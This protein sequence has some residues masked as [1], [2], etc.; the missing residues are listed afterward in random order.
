MNH[1]ALKPDKPNKTPHF[2]RV[3]SFVG[4]IELKTYTY[5][6]KIVELPSE[7]VSIV[8]DWLD[9]KELLAL[10]ATCHWLKDP[11][12]MAMSLATSASVVIGEDV[13]GFSLNG[14]GKEIR[15]SLLDGIMEK[16]LEIIVTLKCWFSK[17]REISC[18][19]VGEI[20][21]PI[22]HSISR[23]LYILT[24][25]NLEQGFTLQLFVDIYTDDP[26]FKHLLQ[27]IN[28]S[29]LQFTVRTSINVNHSD[30]EEIVLG[31]KF[32][33]IHLAFLKGRRSFNVIRFR[34]AVQR[35]LGLCV[36][37]GNEHILNEVCKTLQ[38]E[39][40]LSLIRL[41]LTGIPLDEVIDS[42][43]KLHKMNIP[44]FVLKNS[45]IQTKPVTPKVTCNSVYVSVSNIFELGF[46]QLTRVKVL[47]FNSI[48]YKATTVIRDV[49]PRLKRILPKLQSLIQATLCLR[50][51]REP[52]DY[53]P[54]RE[55]LNAFSKLP[56][57]QYLKLDFA[58]KGHGISR[59]DIN[60]SMP[61]TKL[62]Y[63]HHE[64]PSTTIC[65][66]P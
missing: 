2:F 10:R 52:R 37:I 15:V 3:C 8:C 14:F 57:L 21:D 61:E 51:A 11:A 64:P 53:N 24:K 58:C 6:M 49:I 13:A 34:N 27:Q 33:K 23:V 40:N 62:P 16:D 17:I 50:P 19:R 47:E 55:L 26:G 66:R 36:G 48:D 54:H 5:T 1:W 4:P 18:F 28:D 25:L 12:T 59:S 63:R 38:T 9:Y 42:L 32:T 35:S 7:V 43:E 30:G 65:E 56:N 44:E 31:T 60:R 41:K 29:C 39:K 22:A 46:F 20:G 45:T